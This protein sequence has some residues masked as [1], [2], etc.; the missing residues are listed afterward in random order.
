MVPTTDVRT[1][2]DTFLEVD[3]GRRTT[4]KSPRLYEEST[5]HRQ[6]SRKRAAPSSPLQAFS[7]EYVETAAAKDK[8]KGVPRAARIHQPT[9]PY[10]R[11]WTKF[12]P[13]ILVPSVC[14]LHQLPFIASGMTSFLQ[15][16]TLVLT[17]INSSTESMFH[18]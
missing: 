17:Y 16:W 15:I 9:S 14:H 6:V 13:H 8:T 1:T 4:A 10:G 2:N 11:A 7:G 12:L 18:Y 5:V 3:T